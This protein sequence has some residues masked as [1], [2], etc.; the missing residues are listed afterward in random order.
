MTCSEYL[1]LTERECDADRAVFAGCVCDTDHYRDENGDC[2]P[3][4]SC[5]APTG[6]FTSWSPWG[7]C[8][9]TCGGGTATRTRICMGGG[10]CQGAETETKENVCAQQHAHNRDARL[11][12]VKG[13]LRLSLR[14]AL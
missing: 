13:I 8:S 5:T 10:V 11:N 2:I 14:R 1:G 12:V 3:K 7:P 4:G 6:T 9:Q